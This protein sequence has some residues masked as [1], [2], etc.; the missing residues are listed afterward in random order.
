MT[1]DRYRARTKQSTGVN[2][3]HRNLT[4]QVQSRDLPGTPSPKGHTALRRSSPQHRQRRNLKK[5]YGNVVALEN[6]N[7]DIRAG[8]LLALL[9][10]NGAGK[11]TLVR[12]LLGCRQT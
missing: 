7:L 5:S 3:V 2:D 6:L 4:L 9:G 11:T 1:D 8:E 12:M 10:P